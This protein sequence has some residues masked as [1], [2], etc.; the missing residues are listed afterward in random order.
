VKAFPKNATGQEGL[1]RQRGKGLQTPRIFGVS[2][3]AVA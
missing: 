3:H 2:R 1:P